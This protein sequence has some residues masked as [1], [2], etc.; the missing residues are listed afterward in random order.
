MARIIM[1]EHRVLTRSFHIIPDILQL[2]QRHK[3]EWMAHDPGTYSEEIVREFY[4]SYAATLRGRIHKNT[5][6]TTQDLLTSTMVRGV[7]VDLS[8]TTISRFLMALTLTTHGRTPPLNLTIGGTLC[9]QEPSNEMRI[10][11]RQLCDGYLSIWL[12]MERERNGL[13]PT[14]ADNIV[15]WDRTVMVAALGDGPPTTTPPDE[16]PAS[17]SQTASQAPSS[18]RATPLSGT[19]MLPLARVQKLEGQ[20]ATLLHH[21]KPWMRKLI[22]ESEEKVEKRI[23][24]KTNQ[25]VQA[26]H[27]RLDAFELRVLERP[28]PT[29]DMSSFW[30]ELASLRADVDT[31]LATPVVEP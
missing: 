10:K 21:I 22:A 12:W 31:I 18:S 26:V 20:M 4:A 13:S 11:G 16:H 7:S 24:E 2:F 5:K 9:G 17:S 28:A 23:E 8:H 19:T 3:C 27:K 15:T 6:A 1:E 29:T 30:T 14:M 25:K